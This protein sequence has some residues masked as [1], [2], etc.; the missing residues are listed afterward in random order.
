MQFKDIVGQR[1]IINRMTAAADSGRV[2]HAQ[3]VL[4]SAAAGPLAVALAYLQ[5]LVCEHKVHHAGGDLRADSCG[6][7]PSCKKMQQL[8]H[9]DLHLYFPNDYTADRGSTVSGSE[10]YAQAFRDYLLKCRGMATLEG[11]QAAADG[12]KKSLGIKD[13]DAE[14]LVR[15]VSLKAYEGGWKM[16]LMWLP[17][18]MNT[19][20]ANALLKTLE[21]PTPQTLLL[22]VAEDDT[23][24]LPTVRSRVQY[25]KLAPVEER[26]D[27]AVE[28]EY[29]QLLVRWLR[30]LFKLKMG[31]LSKQVDELAA[32]KRDE[33][34]RFLQY[35]LRVV[36][37]CF[38]HGAAGMPV[39]IGSGDEKFDAMFPQMV[40][41]R[42]VEALQGAI[43]EAIYAVNRNAYAKT[44][45]MQLSFK[46]SKALKNR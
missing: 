46:L 30:M 20:A 25:V 11:W 23:Q 37:N 28:A 27:P 3:L 18:R 8:V 26:L 24:L 21:E 1:D 43:D 45:F 16:A 22:L 12:D 34:V 40:T 41:T 39:S 4:G 29:G 33:Q 17:E 35:A 2:S 5:Y 9:A 44:L 42:N 6:E 7:C 36:R 19:T 14:A 31:E 10:V 32:L 15:A 38:L 13:A